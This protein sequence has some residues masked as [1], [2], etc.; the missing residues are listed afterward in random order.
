[1]PEEGMKEEEFFDKNPWLKYGMAYGK[2]QA[3]KLKEKQ[4][5]IEFLNERR[6]LSEQTV[7]KF[8]NHTLPDYFN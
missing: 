2:D 8:I 6:E 4:K 3:S 1:M 7:K 5:L